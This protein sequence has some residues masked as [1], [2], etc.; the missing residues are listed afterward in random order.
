MRRRKKQIG[1]GLVILYDILLGAL[2]LG[3]YFI[4]RFGPLYVESRLRAAQSTP[5]PT[6]LATPAPTVL[7]TPAPTVSITPEPGGTALPTPETTLPPTPT[8]TVDPRTPWQIRFSDH[9][10][11]EPV[12]TDTSYTSPEVS[13]EI[14]TIHTDLGNG[15]VTYYFADIY[16]ASLDNFKTATPNGRLDY[17]ET[18]WPL[19][20]DAQANAILGIN[21]DFFCL[22][23]HGFYIRNGEAYRTNH[24]RGDICVLYRN[25][26][27]KTYAVDGYEVE[28]ILAQDPI[29]VWDFGPLFL[30][31]DGTVRHEYPDG[32][33]VS[34][35]N[36]RSAVGYYEPGHYCF[37]VADG[38]SRTSVGLSLPEM[39]DIFAEHGCT[40]AYNMDGGGS[41]VM[42]FNHRAFS[43]QSSDN[44]LLSD[45]IIV[46]E[47]GF[48]PAE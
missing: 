38:R 7:S 24:S 42:T 30:Y 18:M 34:S 20:L 16:V 1:I 35:V 31:E 14:E 9:F 29:Q 15:P 28:D 19:D 39:A 48:P 6:V 43:V 8:P 32:N 27:M 4:W 33:T 25:G 36:P 37:L 5:S 13:V 17:Y 41:A 44:R 21:G 12:L 40:R 22:N 47:A 10:T 3:V 45:M 11:Q 46:T 2:F 23:D 26:E